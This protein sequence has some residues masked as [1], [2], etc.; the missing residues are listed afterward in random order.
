MWAGVRRSW[1]ESPG[2]YEFSRA[3]DPPRFTLGA[4]AEAP[5]AARRAFTWPSTHLAGWGAGLSPLLLGR[6]PP[7]SPLGRVWGAGARL[8]RPGLV[9]CEVTGRRFGKR[10]FKK[11]VSSCPRPSSLLPSWGALWAARLGLRRGGAYCGMGARA[12]DGGAQARESP[13]L[14]IHS[15]L[16]GELFQGSTGCCSLAET[17]GRQVA[18]LC[19]EP[20]S[21]SERSQVGGGGWGGDVNLSLARAPLTCGSASGPYLNVCP[22]TADLASKLGGLVSAKQRQT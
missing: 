10:I 17:G 1:A 5:R 11:R 16:C 13:L 18:R 22:E 4:R 2:I 19:S 8:H 20:P 12:R 21:A 15:Q 6:Q 14:G 9:L 7:P 3:G